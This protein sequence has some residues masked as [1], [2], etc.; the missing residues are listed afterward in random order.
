MKGARWPVRGAWLLTGLLTLAAAGAGLSFPEIYGRVVPAELLP[1]A[2]SQDLMSVVAAAALTVLA[3]A[4]RPGRPKLQLAALGILGYLFYAYGIYS[5][6]RAY[7][8]FYLAYLAV[9]ALS[10]WGLV[11]GILAFR[12]EQPERARLPKGVR[13]LSGSGSLLQPLIF[14]PL[15]IAML[16]PLMRSHEQIDSL[17]SVFI[18]D[19]CFIMPAFLI[20]AVSTFQGHWPGLVFTPALFLLGFTLIF[21]LALGELFKP[22]F[23]LPVS[24]VSLWSSLGLS[25]LFLVLGAVHLWKLDLGAARPAATGNFQTRHAGAVGGRDR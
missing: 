7:N 4:A 11:Y 21:S 12:A 10:F 6:E 13:I 23:N 1:G 2:I 24:P 18:L 16:L 8:S 19:L 14:Y 22:S 15:W 20:L 17:Y 9:F 3:F 5:I 25:T